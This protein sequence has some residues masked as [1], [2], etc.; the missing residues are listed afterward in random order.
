MN[1]SFELS[2]AAVSRVRIAYS[3]WLFLSMIFILVEIYFVTFL[4]R[5]IPDEKIS[6]ASTFSRVALTLLFLSLV[7][8]TCFLL[9]GTG[10]VI[11]MAK[12]G[13]Q[14]HFVFSCTSL[15]LTVLIS[16]VAIWTNISILTASFIT[17]FAAKVV[18]FVLLFVM[19]HAITTEP[20]VP[21]AFDAE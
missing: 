17:F 3:L 16:V 15:P 18:A 4:L 1:T 20:E 8:E 10:A 6:A 19:K 13:L 2:D 21:V 7:F 5:S 12:D 14:L 9:S 11:S